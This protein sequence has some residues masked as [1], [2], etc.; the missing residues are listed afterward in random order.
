MTQAERQKWANDPANLK[1]ACKSCNTSKGAKNYP[2]QWT[3][4][5]KYK[6]RKKGR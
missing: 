2:D 1:T 5:D 3:P 6:G 4:A